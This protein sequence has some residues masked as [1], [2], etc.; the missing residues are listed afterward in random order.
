MIKK[1]KVAP[2]ILII[3]GGIFLLNNFGILPW[4]IW[5]NLWKF[6]PVILILIG[7]EYLIGQP[8]SLKTTL[9]LLLLIFLIPVIFA[10]NPFTRNPLATNEL[11]IS[12]P[13]G[14]LIKAKI[15]VDLPATNLN[16]KASTA[17]AELIEGKIS[18]SKAANKPKISTEE[19]FGQKIVKITQDAQ[20]GIP[21]LS[22]LRNNTNLLL[23]GQIPLEIQI[24]TGASKEKIDLRDL[25][26][27]YLE[28]N[29]QASD[30]DI[31]F[32]DLYSSRAKIKTSASSLVI[33]IPKEIDARVKIDSKV[34]NTS[35]ANRFKK[36]NSEY[37][38]K[39]FD[40]AFTR[41]D[42]QIEAVAGSITIK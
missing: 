2:I 10:V 7:V 32:G 5:T 18:F 14:S 4:S 8:I 38:T 23:T 6:W 13:L 39:D 28:I 35:I 41:L 1:F 21:F 29:S 15:I 9:I 34:K 33:K 26:I 24:N 40:K 30:L 11:T 17:S 25:R 16:I 36:V 12:E 37:K 19:S 27:D 42:I 31:T 3:L 20:A 22:S